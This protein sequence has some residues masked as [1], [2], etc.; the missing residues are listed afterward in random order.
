MRSYFLALPLA[1]GFRLTLASLNFRK[2]CFFQIRA[3]H[4]IRPALANDYVESIACSLSLDVD[5][6]LD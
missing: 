5:C 3:L 6:H 4:H 1:A 2:H